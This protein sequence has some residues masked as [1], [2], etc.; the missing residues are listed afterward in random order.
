ML[1]ETAE[2]WRTVF[3]IAGAVHAFGAVFYGLFGDGEVQP[4]AMPTRNN[5]QLEQRVVFVGRD[6]EKRDD[7]ENA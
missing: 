6:E 7:E 3:Y 5:N 2:A 1:Q 4:W